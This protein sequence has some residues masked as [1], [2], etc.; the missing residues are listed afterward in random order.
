MELKE[1]LN[2]GST[3]TGQP[4]ESATEA[5]KL[6]RVLSG[7]HCLVSK[8]L[9]RN[10]LMGCLGVKKKGPVVTALSE[11]HGVVDKKE[12]QSVSPGP[13]YLTFSWR[14][15]LNMWVEDGGSNRA[16]H[17]SRVS[18]EQGGIKTLGQGQ[19]EIKC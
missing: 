11:L 3:D 5:C 8:F 9:D 17:G 13:C 19:V 14:K 15:K 6:F 2:T 12:N 10:I 7:Q 1:E 4:W 18:K 16:C